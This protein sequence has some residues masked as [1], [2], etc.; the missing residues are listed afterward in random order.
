MSAHRLA[1]LAL[2]ANTLLLL[3]WY[4]WL[5]PARTLPAGFVLALLLAPGLPGVALAV[6]RHRKAAFWAGIGALFW[7]SHGV[8]EAWTEPA[9][10]H[11]ALTEIALSMLIVG[12]ASWDGLRARFA[13]KAD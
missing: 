4:G 1:L 3:A 5:A 8:M 7:F 11:L 9:V 13:R 12:G 10:R 6:L 2:L